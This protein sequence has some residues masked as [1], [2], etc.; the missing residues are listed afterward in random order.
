MVVPQFMPGARNLRPGAW[1][2]LAANA[3]LGLLCLAFVAVELIRGPRALP[4]WLALLVPI[5]LIV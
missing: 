2:M 5:S 3:P 4:L 1:V